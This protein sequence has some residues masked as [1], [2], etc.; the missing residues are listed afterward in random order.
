MANAVKVRKVATKSVY[1]TSARIT[2]HPK[3]AK[4]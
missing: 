2:H 4:K 1:K 3:K